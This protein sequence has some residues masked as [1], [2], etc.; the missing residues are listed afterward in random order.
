M[1]ITGMRAASRGQLPPRLN[2]EQDPHSPGII[3]YSE[4]GVR[5]TDRYHGS[6]EIGD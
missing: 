5:D 3:N 2:P 4:P 1:L 6:A